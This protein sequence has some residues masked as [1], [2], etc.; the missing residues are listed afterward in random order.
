MS[1][2]ISSKS[3]TKGFSEKPSSGWGLLLK[4]DT[5]YMFK[6]NMMSQLQQE[7]TIWDHPVLNLYSLCYGD[8]Q[9]HCFRANLKKRKEKTKFEKVKHIW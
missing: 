3:K 6:A 9:E 1:V 5:S 2:Y 7:K 4:I 8:S